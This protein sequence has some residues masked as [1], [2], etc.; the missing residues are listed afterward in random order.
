MHN[1]T[2]GFKGSGGNVVKRFLTVSSFT[3]HKNLWGFVRLCTG[4]RSSSLQ[5][6]CLDLAR[7]GCEQDIRKEKRKQ[8]VRVVELRDG[9]QLHFAQG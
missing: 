5:V 9:P 6:I 2:P 4:S 1:G 7:L 8:E 3:F